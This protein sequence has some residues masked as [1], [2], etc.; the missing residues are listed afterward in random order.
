[1]RSYDQYCSLARALDIVGD[2]RTLLVVR[3][4]LVRPCRYADLQVGLPGI[5]TNLLAERL[6]LLEDTGVVS[7]D[8]QGRYQLTGWGQRLA[9][10][11]R[12]L[13]RW[14]APLMQSKAEADA[15]RGTWFALTAAMMFGGTDPRRP[16][17]AVEIR[18]GGETVSMRSKGGQVSFRPGPADPPD[19][20]LSGPPD[21]IIGLLGGRL[22]AEA[23]AEQGVTIL[24]DARDLDRLRQPDWLSAS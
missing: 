10:P 20:V 9:V 12:E 21:V 4:L 3:E 1:M 18:S 11:V 2:R 5:A 22:S 6:R 23:A 24:G 17:L 7:H 8:A 13:A 16:D 14:G 15:F 19:L